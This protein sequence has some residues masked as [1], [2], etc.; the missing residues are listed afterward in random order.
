MPVDLL[1]EAFR[2]AAADY[3]FLIERGYSKK[4]ALKLT[5]DRYALTSC[6]RTLLYRGVLPCPE[7]D[8]RRR[9]LISSNNAEDLAID[10]YNV[11]ATVAN[12]LYGRPVFLSTDGFLRDA[13][14]VYGRLI[15]GPVFD[16]SVRLLLGFL[17]S[18]CYRNIHILFDRPV[19]KSGELAAEFRE[20]MIKHSL[21]GTAETVRSPD[22]ELKHVRNGAICTSD[23]IIIDDCE[24]PAC[25]L[26]REIIDATF[27][28][29]YINLADIFF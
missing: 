1:T 6:H 21:Q 3:R 29:N 8:R 24:V 11:I 17:E 23:S 25:D 4:S 5:G 13:G 10:G 7:S 9:L 18:G 16:R 12:Y 15:R 19:P 14:E 2:E 26:P 20:E 22:Y 28:P 27:S